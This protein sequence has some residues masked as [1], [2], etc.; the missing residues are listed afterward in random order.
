MALLFEHTVSYKFDN[1]LLCITNFHPAF[2]SSVVLLAYKKE[3]RFNSLL[4]F[5]KN[6]NLTF[7]FDFSTHVHS[8]CM[9]NSHT[10]IVCQL[11]DGLLLVFNLRSKQVRQVVFKK[12]DRSND[13]ALWYFPDSNY[14]CCQEMCA[15]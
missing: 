15:L 8:L 11:Q 3:K 7:A 4:H 1:P 5:D 10:A 12:T 2:E 9:P 14:L 6:S 13:L